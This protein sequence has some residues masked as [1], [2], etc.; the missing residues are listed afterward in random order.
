M[1]LRQD[2]ENNYITVDETG[3]TMHVDG[4]YAGGFPYQRAVKEGRKAG[5]APDSWA[6]SQ[7]NRIR[8]LEERLEDEYGEQGGE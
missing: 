7:Y 2:D 5:M 8:L 3:Y 6:I 1:I 4:W